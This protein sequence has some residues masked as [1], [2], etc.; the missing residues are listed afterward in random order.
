MR[1]L[2]GKT[3]E[4]PQR[5]PSVTTAIIRCVAL[6]AVLLGIGAI[7]TG[8]GAGV[9]R[10]QTLSDFTGSTGQ[11]GI[12]RI[13][14]GS[15][16]DQGEWPWQVSMEGRT[17]NGGWSHFCGGSVIHPRLVLTAAHCVSGLLDNGQVGF[18]PT[19]N[20]RVRIGTHIRETDGRPVSV[21]ASVLPPDWD[22]EFKYSDIAL[23]YLAESVDAQRIT[24]ADN[25]FDLTTG[26][27]PVRATVTG[28]G[29]TE[30]APQRGFGSEQLSLTRTM[31]R[32]SPSRLQ[33]V[34]IDIV[35]NAQCRD[36]LQSDI[37]DAHVC[38]GSQ[39]RAAGSCKGDSGGP[40]VVADGRG[41]YVQVGV[42]SYGR[43]SCTGAGM[44]GVYT[45]VS[46]WRSWIESVVT[47][48][49]QAS[50]VVAG[51]PL[52][53]A[54]PAPTPVVTPA[55]APPAGGSSAGGIAFPAAA[56]GDRVLLVGVDE[57]V[58]QS[59]NFDWPASLTDVQAMERFL[60]S[61]MAFR[62]EQ[63]LTLTNAQ[64]TLTNVL[65]AFERWLIDGSTPGSRVWF[66]FSGHGYYQPDQNGDEDDGYDE[67]LVLHDTVSVGSDGTPPIPLRNALVD[68]RLS[69]LFN[70]L[71]DRQSI[72]LID[73]CHAGTAT[74]SLSLGTDGRLS[75][76]LAPRLRQ[77]GQSL[78]GASIGG[79][80][81]GGA[82]LSRS[83]SAQAFSDP[84]N[85]DIG[86]T[87]TNRP[88]ITWTAVSAAQLALID[89]DANPVQGAFTRRFIT[90][91]SNNDA[92]LNGDGRI[93]HQELLLYL[94]ETSD[95]YCR[96]KPEHCSTGLTPQLEGPPGTLARDVLTG[97]VSSNPVETVPTPAPDP[98]HSGGSS[99]R[100]GRLALGIA[101]GSTLRVGQEV[102][103]SVQSDLPGQLLL[104]QRDAAGAVTQLFPNRISDQNNQRRSI[105]AGRPIRVPDAT[106][107][108]R[109][110]ASP[111]IG[112]GQ[113]FAVV[114]ED[115]VNLSDLADQNTDLNAI[116]D[117]VLLLDAV[118]TRLLRPQVDSTG[119]R[120]P[121]F[122]TGFIDFTISP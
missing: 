10:A 93:L 119:A 99:V 8:S 32:G 26:A 35:P 100:P 29:L 61:Q 34:E 85:T 33:E 109:F 73:S 27:P 60:V 70:R 120:A 7:A 56:P 68:D 78:G 69:D 14:G 54:G 121:R 76:S 52:P 115:G 1:G 118:V 96:D 12:S 90:G 44:P 30:P 88:V 75:R 46:S 2:I 65:A 9:A 41:G 55:P 95:A 84:P 111:P 105:S 40:L 42:V 87:E 89:I 11:D 31:A 79:T 106:H 28:W 18:R 91:V 15:D 63:I 77:G 45:R 102:Q 50:G 117:P 67:V 21:Q 38:A 110:R 72:A 62:P 108:V 59:F 58:Q 4:A 57:H 39:V 80:S 6:G 3:T 107:G 22:G 66:Y 122:A 82:S 104:F 20:F 5:S 37:T 103:F 114:A 16:A 53:G 47:L 97:Q 94:R 48:A 83:V 64:A 17:G 81:L 51:L 112:R 49:E 19:E 98:V 25:R 92:D 43:G 113:L 101:P 36:A 86:F 13:I 71:A 23:L 74:R 116:E 24:L